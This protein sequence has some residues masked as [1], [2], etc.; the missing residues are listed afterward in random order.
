MDISRVKTWRLLSK[1]QG[2]VYSVLLHRQRAKVSGFRVEAALTHTQF[3]WYSSDFTSQ[4]PHLW[5]GKTSP[6]YRAEVR[7]KSWSGEL[8]FLL[9]AQPLI[10]LWM[11]GKF[12]I[13]YIRAILPPQNQKMS[14]LPS[15]T[16]LWWG[17]GHVIE[18]C[19]QGMWP[20]RHTHPGFWIGS[21]RYVQAGVIKD[22][23]TELPRGSRGSHFT[24]ALTDGT[25]RD[26]RNVLKYNVAN[27]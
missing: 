2:N 4:V 3:M 24:A 8:L 21:H 26:D 11:F 17:H 5:N 7:I 9:A 6:A 12:S 23:A 25:F 14:D 19:D 15:Q 22:L 18:A 1:A 10:L 20:I 16:P 27:V 13:W